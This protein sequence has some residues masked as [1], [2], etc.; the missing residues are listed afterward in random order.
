MGGM[1][2]FC[3]FQL[4]DS[5]FGSDPFLVFGGFG[6]GVFFGEGKE[7]LN[8]EAIEK[9]TV[10]NAGIDDLDCAAGTR[11]ESE[12]GEN[13][14]E[15][16]VHAGTT[17]EV[18]GDFFEAAF[19]VVGEI[20]DG[21][22][23]FKVGASIHLDA[24]TSLGVGD[25]EVGFFH[26]MGLLP[27]LI[28]NRLNASDAAAGAFFFEYLETAEFGGIGGVGAAADFPA[29]ITHGIDFDEFAVTFAEEPDGAAVFGG[30][31]IHFLTGD[32]QGAFNDIVDDV[33]NLFK[34]F[35]G[36]AVIVGEVKAETFGGDIGAALFDVFAEDGSECLMKEVGGGMERG[37][38]IGII[39]K[40]ALELL[41]GAFA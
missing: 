17:G 24:V 11:L 20:A 38:G 27:V 33:F 13:P 26:D 9:F 16:A 18:D 2:G 41:F 7:F 40:A 25:E 22:G 21:W 1:D 31:D 34:L 14:H 39:G 29:E 19:K 8:A 36:H 32:G 15:G 6:F 35:R 5:L 30:F 12:H 10:V 4:A 23:A 3:V 37:G 28:D